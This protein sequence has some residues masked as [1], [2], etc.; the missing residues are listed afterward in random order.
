MAPASKRLTLLTS[1]FAPILV[2][3]IVCSGEGGGLKEMKGCREI[4][5]YLVENCA[6]NE[7]YFNGNFHCMH[8]RDLYRLLTPF[9]KNTNPPSILVRH[10]FTLLN[11]PPLRCV[12]AQDRVLCVLNQGEDEV[13]AKVETSL[14]AGLRKGFWE[15][16]SGD[17]PDQGDKRGGNNDGDAHD[18]AGNGSSNKSGDGDEGGNGS[19]GSRTLSNS[20][21]YL[22]ATF[23][24]NLTAL[25]S[26]LEVAS[27]I[28][29]GDVRDCECEVER[30]VGVMKVSV[31]FYPLWPRT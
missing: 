4:F 24:F 19:R 27:N 7:E 20:H 6:Q 12:I 16:A 14:R 15:Q 1:R 9:N 11:I 10:K 2:Y 3:E 23:P 30:V 25:D 31:I 17:E 18:G 29:R 5:D 28:L 26:V 22:P 21:L 13:I 8:P